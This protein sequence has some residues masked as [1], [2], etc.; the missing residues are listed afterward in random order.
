MAESPVSRVLLLMTTH[1]YRSGAFMRAAKRLGLQVVVATEEANP[2]TEAEPSGSLAVDFS[3]PERAAEAIRSFGRTAPLAAV[4]P[5]EDEGALVA[6]H[7]NR[8]LGLRHNPPGAVAATRDKARLRQM[9]QGRP[10]L[11]NPGWKLLDLE[12]DPEELAEE[13]RY[14]SVLKPRFLSGSRG[15]IR[16]DSPGEFVEAFRR[17]RRI[18]KT[19]GVAE[20][21]GDLTDSLVCE[22]YIEGAEV[23][24]EGLLDEGH[25]KV[26]AV[27]DKPDPM[28]GPYFEET[29][30]VTPSRLPSEVIDGAIGA[31]RRAAHELG[32]RTGPVHAELRLNEAGA[33]L[34]EIAARSIGGLCAQTLRFDDGLS[35]EELILQQALGEDVSAVRREDGAAG[36][37]MI[38]IPVPGTL[39]AVDGVDSAEGVR[40]IEQVV[41]TIPLG[42]KVVPLPEGDRYLGFIFARAEE[43]LEVERALRQAHA[44]LRFIIEPGQGS[45]TL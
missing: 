41:L 36:V 10:G 29:I 11:L 35:L 7:A 34:I 2:L 19:P 42:G 38:P 43:P 4:I 13:I 28:Q 17:V 1:T 6:A 5:A 22:D 20:L 16:V 18:V 40:G 3:A 12:T 31:V 15:V 45:G 44:S 8:L 23:A 25:L 27:F 21:G 14:P 26:L 30:Y 9:L 37:M 39:V 33:W 24:V 32:L